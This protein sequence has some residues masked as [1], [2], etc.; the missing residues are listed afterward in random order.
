MWRSLPR[1]R[2]RAQHLCYRAPPARL[3]SAPG[4]IAP[5][6]LQ[7]INPSITPQTVNPSI[8]TAPAPT[9]PGRVAPAALPT[10]SLQTQSLALTNGTAFNAVFDRSSNSFK[11]PLADGTYRLNNGG[12]I[13]VRGGAIVWDAFG[14]IDRLKSG[15]KLA[16]APAALG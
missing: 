12:A 13:R 6:K 2:R 16:E 9:A 3:Q 14:V 11:T 8:K 7:T 5:G 15:Q 10:P 1:S 4:A